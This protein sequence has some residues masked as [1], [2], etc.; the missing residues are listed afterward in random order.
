MASYYRPYLPS[1][2][3]LSDADSDYSN[4][5]T[6][7]ASP[8]A[9]PPN[10]P[11]ASP[12]NSP[13]A[14]PRPENAGPDI[15]WAGGE[16]PNFAALANALNAAGPSLVTNDQQIAY[17][18]NRLDSRTSYSAYGLTDLSGQGLK[19]VG[20]DTPTIIMLQSRDRDK[21]VF[22]QPTN[23]QLFLPR[24][25]KN[26]TEF[27]IVQLNFISAF[28]YFRSNKYNLHSEIKEK[29]RILYLANSTSAP[30][31]T[32]PLKLINRV[33]GGSYNI[34][35][36]L[37]E[38]STQLNRTPL[39]Y[40]FINGFTDFN[41]LFQVTGDYS[42][43]FNEPGDNYY[44]SVRK[45]YIN[46]PTREIITSFYFRARYALQYKYTEQ[47][48]ANAYYYPVLK[49]ILL[50]PDE[51]MSKYNLTY[52]SM[53][54]EKEVMQY[55]IYLFQGLDDP[56]ATE[57]INNN[58][59]ALDTYRLYHTFRYSLINKYVCTYSPSN[60]RVNITTTTLN[61]S[62]TNMLIMQYNSYLDQQL[63]ARG[64][65]RET[66]NSLDT[67]IIKQ[68]SIIQTMYVYMQLN[69]AKYFAI[70]FDTYTREYFTDSN[71]SL[72]LR[73]GLDASGI[74]LLYDPSKKTSPR[75]TDQLKDYQVPSPNFWPFMSNLGNTIGA[76][77]NM[78]DVNLSYPSSS[79]HPYITASSNMDTFREFIDESATVYTDYR[80]KAGDILVNVE[81]GKY[82]IFKFRSPVR[83]TLQIETL[84]R[85]TKFRYPAWN[86]SHKEVKYPV[87]EIFDVSY[88][89]VNPTIGS[90]L[91]TKLATIPYKPVYGWSTI[92][93]DGMDNVWNYSTNFSAT[94]LASLEFWDGKTEEVNSTKSNGLYYRFIAPYPTDPVSKGSNVYTYEYSVT[95]VSE[96]NFPVDFYAFFYHDV[97]AF[98]AD[99]NFKG[100]RNEN[101]YNY[102]HKLIIGKDTKSDTYTFK[103]YAGQ[104]YFM[105]FRSSTLDYTSVKFKVVPHCPKGRAYN[106]LV[107]DNDFDPLKDPMTMLN[108]FNVAKNA[109][110][111]FIRLPVSTMNSV[112]EII[113]GGKDPSTIPIN[114]PLEI[115]TTAIGYDE[116]GISTDL[117]D[118]IPVKSPILASAE[119]EFRID[120]LTEHIFKYNSKYD[121]TQNSYFTPNTKNILLTNNA[122]SVYKPKKV[123]ERQY[124][125]V[126]YYETN[127]LRDKEEV[128]TTI[129]PY[130]KAYN[131][132]TT[133]GPITG[134][135]KYFDEPVKAD[136]KIE[137][138]LVLGDGVSGFTF[139][140]SDGEW[141]I[142]RLSFKTN[143]ISISPANSKIHCLGIF[144]TAVIDKFPFSEV[145]LDTA[146]AICVRGVDKIY[147]SENQNLE[148]EIGLGT[149][150]TFSNIGTYKYDTTTNESSIIEKSTVNGISGF[151]QV[152]GQLIKDVNTYYS[153]IAFNFTNISWD[154]SKIDIPT[155]ATAIKEKKVVVT[156]IKNMV[157][158]PIPYPFAGIASASQLFYDDSKAPTGDFVVISSPIPPGTPYGP[159]PNMDIDKS[160][161]QYEQSMAL[162]NS[163]IHYQSRQIITS[164]K[165]G[166]SDWNGIPSAVDYIHASVVDNEIYSEV[167]GNDKYSYGY[168]LIQGSVFSIVKYKIYTAISADTNPTKTFE[169]SGQISPDQI[170]PNHENTSLIGVSGTLTHFVFLGA[171]NIPGETYSQLRFKEY[172]PIHG[173]L[174]ELSNVTDYKFLNSYNLQHFVFNSSK[175]WFYTASVANANIDTIVLKGSIQYGSPDHNIN[176]EYESV[177]QSEL[178]MD[179]KGLNLYMSVYNN[180][181]FS[182][183]QLFSL[184]SGRK[185]YIGEGISGTN[186]LGVTVNLDLTE[187]NVAAKYYSQFCV[188]MNNDIEEVLL[189]NNFDVRNYYKIRNYEAI[190]IDVNTSNTNI[191]HSVQLL[192]V[193][194]KRLAGGGNGSKWALSDSSPYILGNT[195]DMY[196]APT[197]FATAWQIFFPTLKI[198]MQKL[199]SGISPI[200][201][202][203]NLNSGEN[204]S[205][206]DYPEWPHSMMF[207]YS[208]FTTL[209]ND[210]LNDGGKWGLEREFVVSDVGFNGFDFNSYL[211][212]F[213]LQ[214][215]H[216]LT[217]TSSNMYYYVAVRGYLP[218]ESFQTMMRFYLPNRYDFGFV[219]LS[220]ISI[221]IP[222]AIDIKTSTQFNPLYRET[223]K[224][225]NSNFVFDSKIFGPNSSQGIEGTVIKSTSFGHFLSQYKDYFSK[226][227]SISKDLTTI[228]SNVKRALNEYISSELKYIL[229]AD[230]LIRQRVADPILSSLLW[231][232]SLDN[233]HIGLDDEWGLG[234]NLGYTK[235]DTDYSTSHTGDTFYKIQQ[236]YI[237]LRLNP[238]FNIN[239]MD[240]GG[241]ENYKTS[242]EPSGT[243][244]QYYCKLLLTGFGGNATTFIH[245][246]IKFNPPINRI[247]KLQFQW[248]DA[249][250]ILID[251]N[252]CEWD[253]TVN[254]TEHSDIPNIPSK[255]DFL[256]AD[257]KT[258]LPAPLP[259]NFQ[260]P[261]LQAQGDFAAQKEKEELEGEK[262]A[263]RDQVAKAASAESIRTKSN[264]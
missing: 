93:N 119:T 24:I 226:F 187:L 17:G 102:K 262:Q 41:P 69:F 175:S 173:T 208:N 186:Y 192:D 29:G 70:D 193:P 99:M 254:I 161:S 22:T 251:N 154:P 23:C 87:D 243:T 199:S 37:T 263:L 143:L 250:G 158:T 1:D 42:L 168:A 11:T 244:K 236:D 98:N 101:E 20:A 247:T 131:E 231:K 202:L 162:V 159:D 220:N 9:S 252:D 210:I 165:K 28:F 229:P 174:T 33:R 120:P 241:K 212:N 110:P 30:T 73:P 242:R 53:P 74:S 237:Y 108:N 83:Q 116:S 215:N 26:I 184:I 222:R 114:K 248:I 57:I 124:K 90:I 204:N 136:G 257:P 191:D 111:A 170:F 14:S 71:N 225:F 54:D 75:S 194:I 6:A 88:S 16:G 223:L 117:T 65:T 113:S 139:L 59:A 233:N 67:E 52:G 145:K 62:L 106:T 185:G 45:I 209:S 128:L 96:D 47:Q 68:L 151:S 240:A 183:I 107:Y 121:F 81:A 127:Y 94:Y 34:S 84:P 100:G 40:D 153:A 149:Y 227:Q 21:T 5:L 60:N 63:D 239:G 97:T 146:L 261:K 77:I 224:Q 137:K 58:I 80:R 126:Q 27:S 253:M 135:Y 218:T 66:Y 157:G 246:P 76:K 85:Q 36:I 203:T 179:P 82:T 4:S 176:Y 32:T 10:S 18:E 219:S 232:T 141:S 125:I 172:E 169:F 163:H 104:T 118:Y 147:T 152:A 51:D 160:V 216:G 138:V 144:L 72:F 230:A 256:V 197:A 207:A 214:P 133:N 142:E 31:P 156:K 190:T 38:L 95:I 200:L 211:V 189:L 171:S 44:D 55:L 112:G 198:E 132:E 129:S 115:N 64:I 134:V 25:Y 91:H 249:N 264:R 105:I 180:P 122:K 2:S 148:Y 217:D 15:Q 155:I 12:P 7:S 3:E 103:A 206:S 178:Q 164:N 182:K 181:G 48:V 140:P 235:K 258:G 259:A 234:W 61:T 92:T 56:I 228:N 19:T 39:F 86:K 46:Q 109:D 260:A 167:N 221:E 166:L 49:E 201:D 8:T 78:G 123:S 205:K 130:L 188:V 195:N 177:T 13:T 238:E 79:N 245:N 50:D 255:M 150:H 89:F 196:D 35:E 43:N 213:P